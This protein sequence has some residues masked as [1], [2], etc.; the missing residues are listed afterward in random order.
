[1]LVAAG[2]MPMHFALSQSVVVQVLDARHRELVVEPAQLGQL[3]REQLSRNP[4]PLQGQVTLSLVATISAP[5]TR[6][7]MTSSMPEGCHGIGQRA[8]SANRSKV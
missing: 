6:E 8:S 1:M 7:A 3:E 5:P 4:W 2:R